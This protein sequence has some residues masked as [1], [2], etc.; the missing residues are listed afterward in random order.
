MKAIQL[1]DLTKKYGSRT[2]VDH[3]SLEVQT[4]EIFGFVGPNGAG[5]T[6]TIRMLAGLL[7][8]TGGEAKI[9]EYSVQDSPLEVKKRIGYMPDAFGLYPDLRVWEY[10]DF[11]GSCYQ[12]VESRR[13]SL[14][15]ELLELVELDHRREDMVDSLSRGLKQR[16]SLA[17]ALIHD[18]Q[19]LILDEPA[20]GLDPRARIEIRA[21]L[22]ELASMGKTIFFSTH[23]LS[24]V[25]EICTKVG[26]IEAGSLVATGRLEELHLKF[27]PQRR[28]HVTLLDRLSEALDLLGDMECVTV[29]ENQ[30]HH[31]ENGRVNLTID[32]EGDDRSLSSLLSSLVEAKVPILH[33][34]EDEHDLEEVF[35]RS[36]RGIVS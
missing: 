14:I 13:L 8:P 16:L 17:R 4:G 36:T 32:F 24:D 21:L 3:L 33:F 28:I 23:I 34:S 29:V 35:L 19:V 20:A 30:S 1:A 25:A 7:R 2:A 9:L 6:T 15:S 18:P 31:S 5:K 12:I 26:I 22:S 11:F 10:L 27:M